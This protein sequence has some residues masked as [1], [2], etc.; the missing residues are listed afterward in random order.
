MSRAAE[1]IRLYTATAAI[2]AVGIGAFFLFAPIDKKAVPYQNKLENGCF[3]LFRSAVLDQ[4]GCFELQEDF[5]FGG[6][7]DFFLWTKA[8]DVQVDLN[9][10]AV[11]EPGCSAARGSCPGRSK[12]G[13]YLISKDSLT[14]I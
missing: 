5:A 13:E 1:T 8:S 14:L 12:D 9:G 7:S 4:P 10:R 2:V 3:M 11:T 6:D